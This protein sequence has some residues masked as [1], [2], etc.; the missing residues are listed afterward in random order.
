MRNEYEQVDRMVWVG[1]WA[2]AVSHWRVLND[3]IRRTHQGMEWRREAISK[4][5]ASIEKYS[6]DQGRC[7]LFHFSYCFAKIP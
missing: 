4:G 2:F 1:I 7:K 5:N 3:M 6:G